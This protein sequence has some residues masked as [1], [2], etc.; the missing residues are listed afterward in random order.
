[1]ST[2]AYTTSHPGKNPPWVGLATLAGRYEV[3]LGTDPGCDGIADG[4]NV[5]LDM[6]DSSNDAQWALELGDQACSVSEWH[7]MGN[8]PC[9]QN[10]GGVCDVTDA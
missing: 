7:W 8:T 10:A 9:A 3:L 2:A 6:S 5:S 1:M 4:L